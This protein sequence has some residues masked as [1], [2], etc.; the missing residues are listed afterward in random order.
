MITENMMIE[1]MIDAGACD[2]MDRTAC[3][4]AIKLIFRSGDAK[5]SLVRTIM[6]ADFDR[7]A[8]KYRE[9][10]DK[11]TAEAPPSDVPVKEP[12]AEPRKQNGTTFYGNIT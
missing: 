9:A 3:I 6:G 1:K 4:K 8:E 7:F 2:G 10:I 5:M 11:I 12:Q